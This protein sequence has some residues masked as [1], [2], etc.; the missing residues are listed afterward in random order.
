MILAF[1]ACNVAPAGFWKSYH[2]DLLLKEINDQGP[3]G[4]HRAI[5]WKAGKTNIFRASDFISF[6]QKNGWALIDSLTFT[7]EQTNKWTYNNKA[8]FPLTSAGFSDSV[9]NSNELEHFPRWFGGQVKVYKFQT[10]WITIQPGTDDSIAENGFVVV[11]SNG[12]EMA[13][14]HLWGE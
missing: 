13:V 11:N 7:H 12:T 8:I 3:Y 14:Y 2:K 9:L 10:G 1:A 4:G 6:A 5:Y